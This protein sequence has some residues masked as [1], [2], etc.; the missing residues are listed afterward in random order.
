LPA[1]IVVRA[2]RQDPVTGAYGK[3]SSG[4]RCLSAASAASSSRPSCPRSSGSALYRLDENIRSSWHL[5]RI[6]S[7]GSPSGCDPTQLQSVDGARPASASP[8]PRAHAFSQFGR[9]RQ[10]SFD[11]GET[12]DAADADA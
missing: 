6:Y 12:D 1:A 2:R 7:E 3:A 5:Q 10:P 11:A 8:G 4:A 9:N